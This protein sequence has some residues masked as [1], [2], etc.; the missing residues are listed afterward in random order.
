MRGVLNF[1]E[2]FSSRP[3]LFQTARCYERHTSCKA[4]YRH[5]LAFQWSCVPTSKIF[6]DFH[7]SKFVLLPWNPEYKGLQSAAYGSFLEMATIF[8]AS[9]HTRI[10]FLHSFFLCTSILRGACIRW[11]VKSCWRH[12]AQILLQWSC[13]LICLLPAEYGSTT[14]QMQ[15]MCQNWSHP[16]F[17]CQ[18]FNCA[19]G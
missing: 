7:I 4:C 6:L 3:F 8:F 10:H 17:F 12:D 1:H 16:R 19:P 13:R 5:R 14:H 2:D 18:G 11:A 9:N 15:S